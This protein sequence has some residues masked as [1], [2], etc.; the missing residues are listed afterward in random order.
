MQRKEHMGHYANRPH[1]QRAPPHT[2]YIAIPYSSIN[3]DRE[4]NIM[5]HCVEHARRLRDIVAIDQETCDEA[6][7]LRDR[8]DDF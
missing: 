5:R 1:R 8:H 7:L 2:A 4:G 3:D 6:L